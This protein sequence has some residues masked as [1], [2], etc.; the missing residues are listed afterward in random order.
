MKLQLGLISCS[1]KAKSQ[2]TRFFIN[3]TAAK[4]CD[5]QHT[6]DAD[7]IEFYFTIMYLVGRITFNFL[8]GP[9]FYA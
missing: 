8:H 7:V 5:K 1:E 9:M 6:Y 4:F 3:E 2:K